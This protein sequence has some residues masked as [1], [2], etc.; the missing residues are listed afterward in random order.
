MVW[1]LIPPICR[2]VLSLFYPPGII[3]GKNGK[4]SEKSVGSNK[5]EKRKPKSAVYRSFWA[6]VVYFHLR[7]I[8]TKSHKGEMTRNQVVLT[9]SWVRIPPAPPSKNPVTIRVS[10]F[11]FFCARSKNHP[12]LSCSFH[13]FGKNSFLLYSLLFFAAVS[14]LLQK[15]TVSGN[16]IPLTIACAEDSLEL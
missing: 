8:S 4:N 12:V 16:A 3:R 15:S 6:S 9:G 1:V 10:G 5:S 2:A 11:F 13:N 14:H 7:L